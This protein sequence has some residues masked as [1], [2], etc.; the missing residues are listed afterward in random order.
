MKWWQQYCDRSAINHYHRKRLRQFGCSAKSLGWI[1]QQ[2]QWQRFAVFAEHIDFSE[3]SVLDLGCGFGDF[4]FYLE[5]ETKVCLQHY[6]GIDVSSSFITQAK[7]RD[8]ATDCQFIQGDFSLGRLPKADIVI[9]SG[10]LNYRSRQTDYVINMIEK[11]ASTARYQVGL[12]L[13]D[14]EKINS[15]T[16]LNAYNKRGLA[17]YCKARFSHV[18]CID[19]YSDHDFTL[20]FSPTGMSA[21]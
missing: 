6:M 10:S 14:S 2:S 3:Q 11:M 16:I 7:R 20:L 21:I 12:N 1:D 9:A 5:T 8:F 18:K 17:R 4:L 15:T 19:N 13:L